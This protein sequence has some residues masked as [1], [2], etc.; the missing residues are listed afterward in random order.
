MDITLLAWTRTQFLGTLG[1]LVF[2]LSI[3]V[4]LAWMLLFF[5]WRAGRGPN[6][7]WLAAYRFWVRIFAL[8][9]VLVMGAGMALLFQIGGL[10]AA[11]MERIGNVAG[12]LLG[13]AVISVFIFKSCFLGVMLFGQ[14]RVSESMHTFAVAMVAVGQCVAVF[15]LLVLQGWL[16]NPLGA[17]LFE[18]RFQVY[19][20]A[21]IILNDS[22]WW[23]V[24][25]LACA[26]ALAAV[27]L[28][29]GVT[30]GQALRRRLEE[31]ERVAFHSALVVA[32]IAS[33]LQFA[34]M[35]AS[36]QSIVQH[37]PARAA[38]IAGYWDTGS[39][40]DLVLIA[41]PDAAE[42]TNRGVW[43][44]R[45][46]GDFMLAHDSQGERMALDQFSGMRPPVAA[47]FLT[48]RATV[49][50]G[51]LM[52]IVAWA[53][54]LGTRS[55]GFDPAVLSRRS[56]R[57]LSGTMCLGA[58]A[59]VVRVS[60]DFLGLAP[61]MV[62]NAVTQMEVLGVMSRQSLVMA[63]I[64]YGVLY[65]VLGTAFFVM[66]FHAARYGVVPVRRVGRKP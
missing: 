31:G 64:G 5:K 19:D 65:G 35:G 53:V 22:L 24:G 44:I 1:F 26:A 47:T 21:V 54:V 3:S 37:Q 33:L 4:G 46:A 45:D 52:I 36:Y 16:E 34:F 38:A 15:W 7:A 27:F 8:A 51:I 32:A 17:R 2:F 12:P 43:R 49:V 6:V 40:P 23:R 62:Q 25:Q 42:Q 48:W 56:L 29:M 18:G 55:R 61:Y 58:L 13:Y 9:L 60:G 57:L 39:A 20:W 10:W 50:L 66:L 59:S 30:A 41:W 14:R 11:L 28:I 63:T